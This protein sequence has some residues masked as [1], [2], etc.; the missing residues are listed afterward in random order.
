M[1]PPKRGEP[2]YAE[3][4]E[5]Y[6]ERRRKRLEDPEYRARYS[7]RK[8]AQTAR[9]KAEDKKALRLSMSRVSWN[10]GDDPW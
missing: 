3:Y 4:R 7:A 2:G 8:M 10:L 5:Q 6:N 1:P 9:R